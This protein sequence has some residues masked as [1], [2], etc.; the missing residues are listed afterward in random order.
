MSH[1][2]AAPLLQD[3]SGVA[4]IEFAFTLPLLLLVMLGIFDFGFAFQEYAVVTN[5]AREGARM[6]ALPGY[7]RGDVENRVA[8]YLI[9][10]GVM[11][12]P[13]TNVEPIA[14]DDTQPFSAMKVTVEIVHSFNYV[15]PFAALFGRAPGDVAVTLK[16][17]SLM[18]VEV[19]AEAP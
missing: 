5:A 1:R 13:L 17:V 12:R 6:A 9:A 11:T 14:L 3:S 15:A 4:L 2:S 7:T 10:G 16:A 8:A 19:A 18:R